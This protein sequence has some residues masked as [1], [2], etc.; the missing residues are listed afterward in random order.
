MINQNTSLDSGWPV[1]ISLSEG[2]SFQHP[3]KQD[4]QDIWRLVKET[5]VLDLNSAYCYLLLCEHFSQTCLVARLSNSIVGFVS[6]Y[7]LP[8]EKDAL[9]VWQVAVSKEMQ[10][11][12]IGKLL[13]LNLLDSEAGNKV[14]RVHATV[15]PSNKASLSLF[16][17]IAKTLN[18]GFTITEGFNNDVFP[19]ANH[20]QEDMITIGPIKRTL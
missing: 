16:N 5:A 17:S 18:A 9:F 3:V 11:K 13:V 8:E 4:G 15:S 6:S 10:G 7:V 1:N 20:E 2:I 12:G 14:K 19:D